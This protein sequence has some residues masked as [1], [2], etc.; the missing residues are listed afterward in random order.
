[1]VGSWSD[2]NQGS[3]FGKGTAFMVCRRS[4]EPYPKGDRASIVAQKR[5]NARGAKG[6]RKVEAK[7]STTGTQHR[8]SAPEGST[9]RRRSARWAEA[10]RSGPS[11]CWQPWKRE[12]TSTNQ[13]E[14]S[15]AA[16]ADLRRERTT[17]WRAGCGKSACPVRREGRPNPSSLPL[18]RRPETG[19][20]FSLGPEDAD[21]R[22]KIDRPLEDQVFGMLLFRFSV[23]VVRFVRV[24]IR[25]FARH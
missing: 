23:G 25:V 13:P 12:S 2:M 24:Q 17:N 19:S 6:G 9:R 5:G 3:R 15:M 7:D 14:R 10:S 22:Q 21:G 11:A 1:M 20:C 18:S 16:S 4:E 8:G